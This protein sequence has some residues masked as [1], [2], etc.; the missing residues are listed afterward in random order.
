MCIRVFIA[1]SL[2]A[3]SCALAAEER[4]QAELRFIP[5]GDA[6]KHAG[7]WVDGHYM[8]YVAELKGAKGV[9]LLP[10]S[11]EI[12]VRQAWYQDHVD[13]ILVEPGK[14]HKMKLSLVKTTS[15]TTAPSAAGTAEL[16]IEIVPN[17]AAVF[18]DDQFAGHS[19]EFA[20]AGKA[21]LVQPGERK[22]TIALPGYLPFETTLSLQAN[23][24][25]RVT[26]KL[27][28]GPVKM[29]GSLVS[30]EY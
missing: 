19:D 17:R 18:V 5:S 4:T 6:E 16:K 20:G 14:L 15:K 21:L 7:V 12:V 23:Q 3:L 8:G 9:R 30:P 1:L 28:K 13:Q 10:G 29:A 22:I 25:L 11:H 2:I 27:T 24:K 26:T